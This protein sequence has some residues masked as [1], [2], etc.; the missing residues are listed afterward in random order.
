MSE[1]WLTTLPAFN[2]LLYLLQGIMQIT[3]A[4][5]GGDFCNFFF[6]FEDLLMS[7]SVVMFRIF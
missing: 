4:K 1:S 5:E 3:T 7:L 6:F 2:T